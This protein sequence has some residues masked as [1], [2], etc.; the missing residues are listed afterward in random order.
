MKTHA[1]VP[2]AELLDEDLYRVYFSARDGENRASVGCLDVEVSPDPSIRHVHKDPVIEPG[3][4]G[5]FDDCGVIG[6]W[7]VDHCGDKYLYFVGLTRGTSVPFFFYV[8][9]AVSQ[10]GGRS[11]QKVSPSPILGR[12]SVDPY[13]TGQ[14]CVRIEGTLW[15]MWYV[16]GDR[17]EL[18][19]GQPKHYYHIRYAESRDGVEWDRRGLV[20]IDFVGDEY[21]IARPCV[22]YVDGLYR[23][24][25][26]YRGESY[27]I[28]YAE[29]NDGLEWRR[30]DEQAGIELSPRGWDSEMLAYP[31]VFEHEGQSYMLYNGNGYGKS[32]LG[33]A[34]GPPLSGQEPR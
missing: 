10:D 34:S 9:L 26:S 4:M 18:E 7:V 30:K 14:V 13:L 33:L 20:C 23:M 24:W 8:G 31:F 12:S 16:S 11:F 15:R 22:R 3:P 17:W 6:S 19:D 29:S 21:A 27:R 2:F 25:Y 5:S 32:G 1:A 28:G